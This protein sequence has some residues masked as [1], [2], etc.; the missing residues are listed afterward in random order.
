M[1]TACFLPL[2]APTQASGSDPYSLTIFADGGA[3]GSSTVQQASSGGLN[4]GHVFVGLSN[5]ERQAYIG[6]YDDQGAVWQ[7]ITDNQPKGEFRV[8]ADLASQGNWDVMKTYSI[9]QD[10]YRAAHA[11]LDRW[12]GSGKS[13]KVSC[14]C[15]D[16]AQAIA[17]AAGVQLIDVPKE[18][19]LAN[20]PRLWAKYLREHG[21]VVNSGRSSGQSSPVTAAAKP[22]T[23]SC[24]KSPKACNASCKLD[25]GHSEHGAGTILDE[26][27]R[28]A[29]AW[30]RCLDACAKASSTNEVCSAD[31]K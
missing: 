26:M 2:V 21:G 19:G 14:N 24:Y 9:T 6:F 30:R 5:G 7:R 28:G 4:F 1:L 29:A 3:A 23:Q 20:S 11:L 18:M 12:A 31:L 16:F 25:L 15:S 27:R 13:W 10:G 22:I 8:D 17:T